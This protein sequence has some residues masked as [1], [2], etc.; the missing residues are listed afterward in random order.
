MLKFCRVL[1]RISV[2]EQ[3]GFSLL[4]NHPANAYIFNASLWGIFF[5]FATPNKTLRLVSRVR[6]YFKFVFVLL[7]LLSFHLKKVS[8]ND[9]KKMSLA[10]CSPSHTLPCVSQGRSSK[11]LV[12]FSRNFVHLFT[13]P[14]P[15]PQPLHPIMFSPFRYLL[16]MLLVSLEV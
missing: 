5:V 14:T 16:C 15:L 6:I 3:L 9:K 10:L 13:S 4:N 1:P 7:P 11:P 12:T 8:K 2:L